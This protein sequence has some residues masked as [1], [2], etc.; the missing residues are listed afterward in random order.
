MTFI[1]IHKIKI[2][3][4]SNSLRFDFWN[5]LA[6]H[7]PFKY[8]YQDNPEKYFDKPPVNKGNKY[9]NSLREFYKMYFSNRK[10][11]IMMNTK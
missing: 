5:K 3:I 10:F 11:L 1:P 9:Y 8:F 6:K 4:L 2:F 7:E